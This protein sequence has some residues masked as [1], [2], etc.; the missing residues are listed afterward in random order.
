MQSTNWKEITSFNNHPEEILLN[1][2]TGRIYSFDFN[3]NIGRY[4][5]A[6]IDADLPVDAVIKVSPK[7]E[8]RLTYIFDKNKIVGIQIS[9]LNT[10][11]KIDRINLTTLDWNGVVKLI[12]IFDKLDIKSLASGSLIIDQSL[13]KNIPELEKFLTTVASDPDGKI[14][15]VEVAKHFG[16]LAPGDLDFQSFRKNNAQLLDD[17]LNDKSF[18]EQ[19]K[20][21]NNISKDEDV[22]QQFFEKNDWLLGSDVVEVLGER[23]IDEENIVDLP[24]KSV[25]GFL[26][27]IELKLPS[28]PFWTK[29]INPAADL[30]SAIVQCMD[31]ISEIELRMNDDKKLSQLGVDILKPRITLVYGRT[32]SWSEA[33]YRRLRILNSSFHNITILTYDHILG[34]AEKLSGYKRSI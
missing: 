27:I 9:K 33:M 3:S 30:T 20:I 22:W 4:V 5:S 26:D 14:K 25:D 11:K 32:N 16:I 6:T 13:V 1:R 21:K 15:F 7:I 23:V 34:R 18:F 10:D 24:L 17:L 8:V 29:N 2:S 12:S 28:A 31:Y 19:Y